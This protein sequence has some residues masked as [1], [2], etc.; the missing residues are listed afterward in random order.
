MQFVL[1]G[2][3]A[4]VAGQAGGVKKAVDK[5]R[6]GERSIRILVEIIGPP[7]TA[8]QQG[9]MDAV[10][11]ELRGNQHN[12]PIVAGDKNRIKPRSVDFRNL[13]APS[14]GFYRAIFFHIGGFE[15]FNERA[16]ISLTFGIPLLTDDIAPT[17]LDFLGK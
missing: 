4:G 1:L 8:P 3:I 2:K 14:F 17:M 9:H 16:E 11:L 15:L 12:V 7:S 5:Y 13:S 10:E 6:S